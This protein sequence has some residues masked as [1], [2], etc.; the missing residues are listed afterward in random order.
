MNIQFVI[1]ENNII[2]WFLYQMTYLQQFESQNRKARHIKRKPT[3]NKVRNTNIMRD[4]NK[5][6]K[7][8][9]AGRAR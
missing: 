4:N 8:M 7:I 5:M 2:H 1:Q 9:R 3:R 6:S